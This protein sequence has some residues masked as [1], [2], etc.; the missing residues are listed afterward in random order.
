M[1]Y[2]LIFI[3][4]VVT[5][6]VLI[7]KLYVVIHLNYV[8]QRNSE[9]EPFVNNKKKKVKFNKTVKVRVFNKNNNRF[10]DTYGTIK[11]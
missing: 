5:T 11:N 9:L 4:V 3:L 1:Y 7:Y 2:Q 8:K 6:I 10:T